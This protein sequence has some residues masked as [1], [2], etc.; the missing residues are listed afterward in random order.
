MKRLL[1]LGLVMLLVGRT[2]AQ[3]VDSVNSGWYFS[4]IG[5][6]LFANDESS[7]FYNGRNAYGIDW[8][9]SVQTYYDQIYQNVGQRDFWVGEYP[10]SVQNYRAAFTIGANGGYL[11]NN[12]TGIFFDCSITTLKTADIWLIFV[13]DPVNF[14]PLVTNADIVGEEKRL[15]IDLG[16][17]QMLGDS[18]TGNFF[19]ELGASFVNTKVVKNEIHINTLTYNLLRPTIPNN[20]NSINIQSGGS[21]VGGFGGIGLNYRLNPNF[22]VDLG[23]HLRFDKIIL[24][25]AIDN[26]YRLQNLLFCRLVYN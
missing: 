11:F 9:L 13:D 20:P 16:L 22:S 2:T 21:A 12:R 15:M 25:P 6:A 10:D 5:G 26:P 7:R 24:D 18:P 23:L 19:I 14:E 8:I 4:G 3:E 1:W 17:R